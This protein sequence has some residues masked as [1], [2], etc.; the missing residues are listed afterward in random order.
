MTHLNGAIPKHPSE[1]VRRNATPGLTYLPAEGHRGAYPDWPLNDPTPEELARWGK[2]WR[3]PQATMWV[4]LQ[5]AETVAR[6][7]RCALQIETPVDPE[8]KLSVATANLHSEVRQL[9]DRLGLSPLSMLRLRW[10][11]A[12]DE[13]GAARGGG[14]AARPKRR[15]HAVDESPA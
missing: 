15:L 8:S 7:V 3:T 6:Y 4:R 10:E 1:R 13:V 11:V 9:E 14:G 2:V 12:S 5:I